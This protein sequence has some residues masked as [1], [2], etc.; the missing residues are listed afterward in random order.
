MVNGARQLAGR[1]FRP[2]DADQ[3][4]T[5]RARSAELP[6]S[7][8]AGRVWRTMAIGFSRCVDCEVEMRPA[9]AIRHR[10]PTGPRFFCA[11]CMKG[12]R[13]A[14]ARDTDASRKIETDRV[15]ADDPESAG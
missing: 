5:S 9:D 13:D 15:E 1:C 7:A 3:A 4:R 10:T 12:K 6:G 8:L 2:V 11:T 14:E